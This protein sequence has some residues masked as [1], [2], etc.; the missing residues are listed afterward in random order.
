MEPYFKYFLRYKNLTIF[1]SVWFV[2]TNLGCFWEYTHGYTGIFIMEQ[3]PFPPIETLSGFNRRFVF[4]SLILGSPILWGILA[5]YFISGL[6][7][8]T[9]SELDLPQTLIRESKSTARY[10]Y[11]SMA[12]LHFVTIL[13]IFLFIFVVPSKKSSTEQAILF[14]KM[15]GLLLLGYIGN[16]YIVPYLKTLAR[17]H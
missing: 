9:L 17:K 7:S 5:H 14:L 6:R 4:Y 8:K 10:L 3:K 15:G 13:I 16:K 1:L 11:I 12:T 2:M